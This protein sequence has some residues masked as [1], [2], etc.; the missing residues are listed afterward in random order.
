MIAVCLFKDQFKVAH[1][2]YDSKLVITCSRGMILHAGY[3]S[4][5]T[6]VWPIIDSSYIIVGSRKKRWNGLKSAIYGPDY[7]QRGRETQENTKTHC[8]SSA[9]D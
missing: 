2:N 8:E 1:G 9:I 5:V 7:N 3:D 4:S 6:I